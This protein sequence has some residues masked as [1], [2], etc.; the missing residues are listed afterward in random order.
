LNGG[1]YHVPPA[2]KENPNVYVETSLAYP[3]EIVTAL[4]Q[5]GSARVIFGSD[6]PYS[7]TKIELSNLL[8]YDLMQYFPKIDIENILSRNILQLMHVRI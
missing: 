5:F 6:T 1:S 8:E 2:F 4:L 3:F 7:S